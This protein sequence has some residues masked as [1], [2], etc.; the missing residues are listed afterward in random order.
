MSVSIAV[1]LPR[2]ERPAALDALARA[3]E[4]IPEPALRALTPALRWV[5]PDEDLGRDPDSWRSFLRRRARTLEK[6]PDLILPRPKP[7]GLAGS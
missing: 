3:S 7:N 5:A 4:T 6:R 1:R 2:S